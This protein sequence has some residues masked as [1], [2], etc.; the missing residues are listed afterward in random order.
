MDPS[1]EQQQKQLINEGKRLAEQEFSEY[2]NPIRESFAKK[3]EGKE[4]PPHILATTAFALNSLKEQMRSM[5]ETTKTI[6]MGTFADHGYKLIAAV[7][8]NL[9]LDKIVSMQPLKIRTGDVFYMDF[10]AKKRKGSVQQGDS[11]L[12][13]TSGPSN[14]RLYT[15]E[16]V[17]SEELA[18][19]DGTETNFT[20]NLDYTPID[21]GTVSITDGV[22]T[23]S[24]D[25]E[26]VLTGDAGGS[27]TVNYTTGAYDVTFNAAPGNG[28]A[29]LA[30]YEWDS[31]S[32]PEQ[33]PEVYIDL[34]QKPVTARPYRLRY[35]Y[36]LDAAFD[37]QQAHGKDADAELLAA[38]AALIRSN[39]DQIVME[40]LRVKANAGTVSFDATVPTGISKT[41]HYESFTHTLTKAA[42]QIYSA[43][44][45][46][47]ASF[48]IAGINAASIIEGMRSFNRSVNFTG[49]QP[50]GPHVVG[51]ING[52][53]VVKNAA[54]PTN[55]FV[56][57]YKGPGNLFAG[58][59]W[60]PYRA[61]YT[62]P[63]IELD[64]YRGRRALYTSAGRKMLND[65]F[66]VKGTVSNYS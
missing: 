57:G 19:G 30:D 38:T 66:Y 54:Y 61:L 62:S 3:N 53:M 22:E 48:V 45:M 32:S 23:F 44:Q 5:D 46:V 26:G 52:M 63:R 4:I 28:Q 33:T 64:D 21:A 11:L 31:E 20:G 18:T 24:D 27:G 55:E 36:T 59:V 49:E 14:D 56:V 65:K 47:G 34:S 37:L 17:E 35:N 42:N 8:P 6:N 12:S 40:D 43:T 50:A 13:A 25:G 39:L 7:L 41:D 60:A 10:K 51:D 16:E 29:L 2:I 1:I 15:S 9:V 58:Y